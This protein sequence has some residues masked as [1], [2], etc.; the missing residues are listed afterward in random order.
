[1]MKR[2]IL[3]L[4]VLIPFL[5]AGIQAQK[6]PWSSPGGPDSQVVIQDRVERLLDITY[7]T[8]DERPLKLDLYRPK[9][10]DGPFPG[11]VLI[12]G[13]DPED[14]GKS[15]YEELANHLAARGFVSASINYRGA[16][17]APYPGAIEDAKEAVS[18]LREQATEHRLDPAA[19]GAVGENFGGYLAAMLGVVS[20]IGDKEPPKAGSD[21]S[22]TVQ[23]VL[24]IHP[25]VDLP[26]YTSSVEFPWYL[27]V[28]LGYPYAQNPQLWNEA[29]PITYVDSRTAPFLMAHGPKDD[30]V[31]LQQSLNLRDALLSAGVHAKV[32]SP[33]GAGNG[34]FL[35]GNPRLQ[36]RVVDFFRE[37]LAFPPSGVR[38]VEDLVFGSPDGRD[39]LLD[40]FVPESN[41]ARLPAVIFIHGGGWAFGSKR[42]WR[43][44]AAQLASSGFVTATI[45]YR[46]SSERIYPAAIDDAKAAVR[47]LRSNADLY[48]VDSL[49]IGVVGSSA[50][51]VIASLLGVTGDRNQMSQGDKGPPQAA[52]VQAVAAVSGAYD[53]FVADRHD[54]WAPAA[55]MGS[56]PQQD[57]ERW[58]EASPITHVGA[59]SAPHLFFHGTIDELTPSSEA[60]RMMQKLLDVG[61]HAELFLAEGGDHDFFLTWQ[62][63][64]KVL[65]T[66]KDFFNRVMR[67]SP[68]ERSL[69]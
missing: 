54:A 15:H 55:F 10:G 23:A 6:A 8:R 7:A 39:L 31:P 1:M 21:L 35:Q 22:P 43:Y 17:D 41:S 47:W 11:I 69:W 38:M 49:Q 53:M 42:D 56:L 2:A 36:N 52:R 40:L 67:E 34:S 4:L 64:R 32:Y 3:L 44:A 45:E 60:N 14:R 50:G 28:F 20:G 9:L 13:E 29:S 46:L 37:H 33:E 57:P 62:W 65:E 63:E 5:L 12:H 26:A 27:Q 24:A 48:G 68:K 66:L 59:D 58:A 19:I 61:V 18:W 51:G 30:K 25:M 16:R